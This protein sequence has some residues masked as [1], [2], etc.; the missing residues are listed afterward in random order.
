MSV[1]ELSSEQVVTRLL[2]SNEIIKPRSGNFCITNPDIDTLGDFLEENW[3]PP[4][5]E[6]KEVSRF[7]F[8]K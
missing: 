3:E 7:V 1:A 6:V 2:S 4:E 8:I 5:I